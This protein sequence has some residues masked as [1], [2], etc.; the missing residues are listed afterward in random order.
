VIRGMLPP[1]VH[2]RSDDV[3]DM[4]RRNRYRPRRWKRAPGLRAS[5][6]PRGNRPDRRDRS[7]PCPRNE[8][9]SCSPT[10]WASPCRT[11]SSRGLPDV[12][13]VA[14]EERRIDRDRY[15]KYRY[16]FPAAW[17]L[18]SNVSGTTEAERMRMAGG[19]RA[20]PR[21]GSSR[22]P[23]RRRR[24]NRRPAPG[25]AR[26][27]RCVPRPE[28]APAPAGSGQN[29]FHRRLEGRPVGWTCHPAL[30]RSV[31]RDR[32]LDASHRTRDIGGNENGSEECPP[33]PAFAASFGA[34]RPGGCQTAAGCRYFWARPRDL[35]GVQSAPLRS[36]SP[37]THRFRQFFRAVVLPDPADVAVVLPRRE[38][39]H[40]VDVVRRVVHHLAAG[41]FAISSRAFS[42]VIFFST[43][44]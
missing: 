1:R 29:L 5:L 20:F 27:R 15:R 19:R 38:Q 28:R 8:V 14:G 11:A 18:A 31:V 36:W 44:R 13:G 26:P 35:H 12:P 37:H 41:N 32:Q 34:T 25:R 4:W 33:L 39:R 2:H 42:R 9:K 7:H 23:G 22:G 24:R 3:A 40:R 43:V 10:R 16:S 17:R 30:R 21:G 6:P